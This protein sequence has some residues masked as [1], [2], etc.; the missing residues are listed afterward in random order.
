MNTGKQAGRSRRE[1]RK[2]RKLA[3]A[4][5]QAWDEIREQQEVDRATAQHG[6]SVPVAGAH[7]PPLIASTPAAGVHSAGVEH[8]PQHVAGGTPGT[9]ARKGLGT[10]LSALHPVMGAFAFVLVLVAGTPLVDGT[11]SLPWFLGAGIAA[12]VLLAL[13][14]RATR[15]TGTGS[16]VT[17]LVLGLIVLVA[18][19]AGIVGQN[20]VEGRAQLRGSEI[21]VAVEEHRELV[22]TLEVLRENQGLLS[23]PPE[24]A[25]PLG[26]VYAEARQQAI[27]IGERWNPATKA[28]PPLP[29]LADAYELVNIAAAQQAAALDGFVANLANPEPAVEAAYV[30]R[31]L[32]V[33]ALLRNDI[34]RTLE[35][36]ERAIRDSVTREEPR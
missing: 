1:M 33:D 2:S 34:P 25:I 17:G 4:R 15:G 23:L 12:L 6:A 18:G 22:R 3:I 31:G 9:P 8:P 26:A 29:E 14:P 20:V 10:V 13:Y 27:A 28:T 19:I 36:V 35:R 32:V 5:Q 11:W 30:E 24:Q 16:Q 7:R 21:D